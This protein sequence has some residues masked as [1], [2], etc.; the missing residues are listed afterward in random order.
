MTFQL[1][2][3]L[4]GLALGCIGAFN[5]VVRKDVDAGFR[6]G[7]PGIVVSLIALAMNLG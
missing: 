3:I 4:T 7:I 6:W 2:M 5:R 1:V